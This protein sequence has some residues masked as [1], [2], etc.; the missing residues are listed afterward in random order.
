LN[1]SNL[2]AKDKKLYPK[3]C[4]QRHTTYSGRIYITVEYSQDGKVMDHY[5]RLVGQV[6]IMVK[7]K[8]C[9][10]HKMS[11]K[12]MVLK[13]E[14]PHDLGGYFVVKGNEKLLRLLIMPRRN[15]VRIVSSEICT[16]SYFKSHYLL[17]K[18]DGV[19]K[20]FMEESRCDLHRVWYNDALCWH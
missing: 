4:R 3:E 20:T 15:Y 19:N 14:E 2:T 16:L 5:E 12:E 9:N 10:L 6:P 11:P 7:S 13:G 17:Q 1:E 8:L 18:G